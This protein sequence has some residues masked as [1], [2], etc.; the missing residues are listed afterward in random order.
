MIA[1]SIARLIS[2]LMLCGLGISA[3]ADTRLNAHYTISMIGVSIGQVSWTIDIGASAYR[4]SASGKASGALSML[5]NGEGQAATHGIVKGEHLIPMVFSSNVT[6]DGEITGL[7]M[8][9]ENDAV[10]TLR[11][12]APQNKRGRVPVT[13]ADRH[14]VTD[15]M[16]AML[17]PV[18]HREDVL[19]PANCDHVLAIFD[20]QRRYNLALSFKRIDSLVIGDGSAGPVLAC[21]VMLQPIAGHRVDSMLVKYVGGRHNMELW[22]AP[23]P[24]TTIVVPVRLLM[25][26]MIGTLEIKADRFETVAH[27]PAPVQASPDEPR[28]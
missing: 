4:A 14:G 18:A 13:E 19:A 16:T 11:T 21:A 10:K 7:Q 22:F 28:P 25:P 3:Q 1:R 20:G 17:I 5:V 6:D 2:C 23:I 15:P 26:T 9:F 12:D 27:K 8:T 24:D